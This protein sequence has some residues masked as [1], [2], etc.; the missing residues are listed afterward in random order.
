MFRLITAHTNSEWDQG[1]AGGSRTNG[2][3]AVSTCRLCAYGATKHKIPEKR[4]DTATP[5]P[6]RQ[7]TCRRYLNSCVIRSWEAET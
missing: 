5:V 1:R 3:T 7:G 6:M 4:T 2:R